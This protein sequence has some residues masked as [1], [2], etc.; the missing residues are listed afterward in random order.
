MISVIVKLLMHTSNKYGIDLNEKADKVD[1][2]SSSNDTVEV[3]PGNLRISFSLIS[4]QMERMTNI[5]T[6][7]SCVVF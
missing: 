6:G 1:I 3:G 5:K 7:V 4:G 2:V